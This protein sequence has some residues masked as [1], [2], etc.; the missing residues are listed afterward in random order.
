MSNDDT[1]RFKNITKDVSE[2]DRKKIVSRVEE[3]D[4]PDARGEELIT[5]TVAPPRKPVTASKESVLESGAFRT[6]MR[7]GMDEFTFM[8]KLVFQMQVIFLRKNQLELFR[9]Y[10]LAQLEKEVAAT[11][12]YANF[13]NKTLL[14]RFAGELFDLYKVIAPLKAPLDLMWQNKIALHAVI[15]N[16]L[17]QGNAN[18]KRNLEDFTPVDQLLNIFIENNNSDEAVRR[19]ILKSVRSYTDSLSSIRLKE[20]RNDLIPFYYLHK[21]VNYPFL[22]VFKLF[23]VSPAQVTD[24]SAKPVFKSSVPISILLDYLMKFDVVLTWS[25]HLTVSEGVTRYMYR[26]FYINENKVEASGSEINL[27]ELTA[28]VSEQVKEF[29]NSIARINRT[30]SKFPVAKFIQIFTQ[31]PVYAV[32]QLAPKLD[33]RQFYSD[34]FK[35]IAVNEL[36]ALLVQMRV[37][38]FRQMLGKYFQKIGFSTIEFYVNNFNSQ[39]ENSGLPQFKYAKSFEVMYNFLH[40]WVPARMQNIFVLLISNVLSKVPTLQIQMEEFKIS[41]D[42]VEDKLKKFDKSLGFE[43]EAGKM[44]L[45]YKDSLSGNNI[46]RVKEVTTFVVGQDAE[47]L[48]LVENAL[49]VLEN[50]S[51]FIKTKILDGASDTLK[52]IIAGIYSGISRSQ[53]LQEVLRHRWEDLTLFISTLREVIR[54]EKEGVAIGDLIIEDNAKEN[55]SKK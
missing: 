55:S 46:K 41:L 14:A 23:G 47:A 44:L 53:S 37:A 9:N 2:D 39:W 15:T 51:N 40:H 4:L 8:E 31:N 33:V 45:G 19:H 30:Q 29:E 38:Y 54:Y 21:L 48:S 17:E 11:G 27:D 50:F 18:V 22:E 13:E 35:S 12:N 26:E 20:I 7:K 52:P 24:G 36:D 42:L 25:S 32:A 1:N 43:S 3:M 16:L 49:H 34:T 10:Y 5:D 28:T 6:L